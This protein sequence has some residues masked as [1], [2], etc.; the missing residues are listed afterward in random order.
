MPLMYRVMTPDGDKPKIG[1]TART[2]GVR[3]PP[4]PDFDIEVNADGTV[5]PGKGG[6]SVSP[7]ILALPKHRAPVRYIAF[8]PD[9]RGRHDDDICWR[10][11]DGP[12][13]DGKIGDRLV[14]RVDSN[15]HGMVEP[16]YRMLLTEYQQAL[17]ATQDDWIAFEP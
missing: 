5:E 7:D 1:N 6:M 11:S 14:L 13:A 9:A 17:A 4:N 16:A 12:F 3:V 15:D 10:M 2:L 8:K